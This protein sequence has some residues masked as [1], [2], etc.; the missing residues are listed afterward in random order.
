MRLA[1]WV[2]SKERAI[3]PRKI[4]M[5]LMKV[6]YLTSLNGLIFSWDDK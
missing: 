1:Q 6:K 2:L 5:R 4:E 3:V